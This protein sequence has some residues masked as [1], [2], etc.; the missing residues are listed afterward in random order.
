MSRVALLPSSRRC[1]AAAAT[2]TAKCARVTRSRL[3]ANTTTT[4]A[5]STAAAGEGSDATP[6]FSRAWLAPGLAFVGVGLYGAYRLYVDSYV[7]PLGPEHVYR[8][9]AHFVRHSAALSENLLAERTGTV[10]VRTKMDGGPSSRDNHYVS[11]FPPF[12]DPQTG[13]ECVKVTF[14]VTAELDVHD[15]EDGHHEAFKKVV[16]DVECLACVSAEAKKKQQCAEIRSLEVR[17]KTAYDGD[18]RL[19]TG[20]EPR[21]VRLVPEEEGKEAE[22]AKTR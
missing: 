16:G 21:I 10:R 14:H 13:E 3:P 19:S 12:L 17:L 22:E 8:E 1:C 2:A 18:H 6:T 4:R 11:H 15:H 20:F 9:A 7:D 5:S